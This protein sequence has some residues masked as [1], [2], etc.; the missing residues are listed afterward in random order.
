MRIISLKLFFAVICITFSLAA[1]AQTCTGSLG[2]PIIN[3]DFGSGA[4]LGAPLGGNYTSYPY[5]QDGCPN[6]GTYTIANSVGNCFTNSWHILT[7]DH[8]GNPN[9]YM[10][11]VNA[12]YQ[13]GIFYVQQTTAGQLCPNTTY[14]FAAWILNLETPSTCGGASIKPNITFSIE[15]PAGA[16]IQTY[17]TGDIPTSTTPQWTQYGTFFTTPANSTGAVVVKMINNAPGGCGNDIALDDITFRAC[18]PV[19]QT[20][21]SSITGSNA[22]NLCEGSNFIST[23]KASVVSNNTLSYQ[24]QENISNNLLNT[25]WIDVSAP[26]GQVGS[27]LNVS[28]LTARVGTY[29]WRLGVSNGSAS[30]ACRVYSP[31]LTITVTPL[32]VVPPIPPQTICQGSTLTL[33]ASGG[34][35]YVWTGP[36]ITPTN[37]NPL[38][39][40]NAAPANSGAYS[41]VATSTAGCAAPPVQAMV[42]VLPA[43]IPTV[44]NDVTICAG[45]SAPLSASGGTTYKWTPAT[46]LDH[47]DIPNPTAT[48]AITTTYTVDISNGACSDST[49][50][51]TVTVNQNP[52][53]NAGGNKIL[54]EG[55]SAK[56][57]GSIQ[58]DNIT[59][60]YWT[61]ATFLSDPNVL[62]PIATPTGDITYTLHLTS[63]TCGTSTSDVFIK[64]YKKITIP[65]AFSPNNDGINDYWNI[66]ALITY[67]QSTTFV[68]D[69]Y[70][71]KVF[72]STGYTKPWDGKYNGALLPEGT[73]YYI[74]DLKNGQPKIAGWVSLLR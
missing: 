50:S 69:R 67:P 65:N 29:Q 11:I 74:I 46:G 25:G 20:G 19:I 10:M 39:I 57:N 7:G 38:V 17:Q 45:E 73:Y 28:F 70:G 63:Q 23:I 5:V 2:D 18:G 33:T 14:E 27:S 60:F 43:I 42:T 31:P 54:F 21:F 3:Q 26:A 15:T 37:Q 36:N 30:A 22:L 56:L 34:T 71:Q 48:P 53:A 35:S 47:N 66:D 55:Q 9:G 4:G 61:P 52:V 16:I 68:Y 64:V 44:S 13:P 12:S 62:M 72:E 59:G 24:W 6:D 58:G 32:P 51:V 49:K 1:S 40:N 8:T 41:V